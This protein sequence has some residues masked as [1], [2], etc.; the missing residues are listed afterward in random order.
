MCA[1]ASYLDLDFKSVLPKLI[2]KHQS[3]MVLNPVI[4]KEYEFYEC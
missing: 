3:Y 2:L 4:H 1:R